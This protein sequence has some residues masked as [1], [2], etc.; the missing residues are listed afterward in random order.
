M[1]FMVEIDFVIVDF[2]GTFLM[3]DCL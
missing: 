2:I 3:V 1:V